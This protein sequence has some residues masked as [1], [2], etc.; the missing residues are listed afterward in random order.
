MELKNII[1]NRIRKTL[2]SRYNKQSNSNNITYLNQ[3]LY[4]FNIVN[5]LIDQSLNYLK[6]FLVS[7]FINQDYLKFF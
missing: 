7:D 4:S 5:F 1:L 6:S 2:Q 3:G